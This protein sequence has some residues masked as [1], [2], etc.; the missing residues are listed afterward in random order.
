VCGGFSD[1]QLRESS[2]RLR[3]DVLS[4]AP[5]SRTIPEAFGLVIE[6]S[7]RVLDLEHFDVQILGGLEL[8][9]QRIAE[10]KTG[11][12]KTL[13]AALPAYLFALAG[14][15]VHIAT[16]NDYLA[17]RDAAWIGP[18]FQRLGLTVGVVQSGDS[19]GQRQQAYRADVTYGTARQFGFDFL[20]DRLTLRAHGISGTSRRSTPVDDLLLHRPFWF[21]L[22]DEADS[23]LIDEARTP[24]VIATINAEDQ[25]I[26]NEC[27]RWAAEFAPSFVEGT[28]YR[29]EHDRQKVRL[30]AAGLTRLRSLPQN[31]GTRRVSVH[32]LYRYMENAIKVNRDYQRDRSYA[33]RDRQVVIIDEFTG[34]I[35]EG[36]QWQD[37]IHQAVQAKEALEI[38]PENRQTASV[39]IQSWARLYP[40]VA[41]MTGTAW[42]ARREFRK[43]Y[44]KSV[45]RIPRHRPLQR[46]ALPVQVLNGREAKW[47]AVVAETRQMVAAG[48]AV[49]IGTRTVESSEQLAARLSEAEVAH[50]VLNARHDQREAEI[51]AQAGQPRRVTVA[52]NMAGRGTDIRLHPD[53]SAAGGLHVILTEI[54]EAQR[55]DWQMIGRGCR[56][57]DPGSY[58]IF[59]SLD[60]EILSRG[61]G[62]RRSRLLRDRYLKH[63]RL[64]QQLFRLFRAAQRRMERRHLVDR[65]I[66]LRQDRDRHQQ[67]FEM[68][69]DPYLF[70]THSGR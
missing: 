12:G 51:I 52:T 69:L 18:V 33:V 68:G 47:D 70:A 41:G 21:V 50:Q 24:L 48:R 49:L 53:V 59:V 3:Y 8:A 43:V 31:R 19:A 57:G 62:P 42:T 38:T 25:A 37:G 16:V 56:Q 54:H 34:R 60:D 29:Y 1:Q 2:L 32:E 63:Q 61:L 10:M 14:K 44:R 39:T 55:I 45:T 7:R 67:F 27:L 22:F 4:G 64:P 17:S 9:R 40:H 66:L 65:M 35:A 58:R 46:K 30:L 11:E 20:R 6:A 28:D 15:G 5:L 36:R 26:G 23:I 13:T